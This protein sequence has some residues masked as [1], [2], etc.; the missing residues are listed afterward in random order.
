MSI[1][2]SGKKVIFTLGDDSYSDDEF[3]I[4]KASAIT[5]NILDENEIIQCLTLFHKINKFFTSL[6]IS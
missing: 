4:T 6:F 2:Q 1:H 3:E 5:K